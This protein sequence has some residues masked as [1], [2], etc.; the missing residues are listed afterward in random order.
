MFSPS[1]EYSELL[2]VVITL[3]LLLIFLYFK[4]NKS[5]F[6]LRSIF[7]TQPLLNY[8]LALSGISF[9]NHLIA[10][11]AALPLPIFIYCY[12]FEYVA[13]SLGFY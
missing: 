12:F 5:I 2:M 7:Q 8:G 9:R 3:L 6:I 10:T 13:L 4:L 1:S 11:V